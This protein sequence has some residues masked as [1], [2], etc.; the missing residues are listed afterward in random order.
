MKRICVCVALSLIALA[1]VKNKARAQG[2][3]AVPG[4]IEGHVIDDRSQP[5]RGA[6]VYAMSLNGLPE[7]AIQIETLTDELGRFHLAP[8]SPG[9]ATVHA[10]KERDGYPDTAFAFF[11]TNPQS[12]PTVSVSSGATTSGVVVRLGP[13][14]GWLTGS[15][16]DAET[17][18]SVRDAS[19]NLS[20][21]DPPNISVSTGPVQENGQI[22]L[23][24]PS[25][26]GMRLEVCAPHYHPWRFGGDQW[27]GP[28][29]VIKVE[30]VGKF[31][32]EI[33]L[34]Q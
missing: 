3:A 32:L 12:V 21:S 14:G 8:V 13:K 25:S 22:N 16:L 4:S 19:F 27:Q 31:V 18:A 9:T 29:G 2:A 20:R 28:N 5:M 26:I 10:Y 7:A 23:L 11:V 30:P 34:S 6:T 17:K 1:A 24:V 33:R 15:V